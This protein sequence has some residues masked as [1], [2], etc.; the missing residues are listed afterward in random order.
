MRVTFREAT[1]ADLDAMVRI[2]DVCFPGEAWSRASLAE[3]LE[4]PGGIAWVAVM[5][6]DV[7]GF[8]LGMMGGDVLDVL[9]V[10]VDPARQRA[11][12]GRGLVGALHA[13]AVAPGRCERASE[14]FLEVRVDNVAAIAMYL[15][16]GYCDVHI[17]R[18][19][20]SDGCDARVM[21]R[22]LPGPEGL[23]TRG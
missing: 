7:A 20:Y 18:R 8:A 6:G 22:D 3:E 11:G 12:V 13:A 1:A 16:C 4:R 17:R 19:Y 15:A 9:Q 10:A 5:G 23:S 2:E 14:A 21:R